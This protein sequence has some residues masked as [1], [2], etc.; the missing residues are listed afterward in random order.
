MTRLYNDPAT[1]KDDMVDG[2]VSAYARYVERVPDAS[3]VMRVGG[4]VPG[5]VSVIVGGGSGHY[6]AFCGL[7]GPGLAAGAVIGDIFTSPSAEQAYRVGRALDGG[8]GVLFSYGNY[9]GDVMNFGLAEQRLRDDGIDCRTVLVTDDIASAPVTAVGKR[10]GIAG[11]F[12]VFKVA[13]AAAERGD[14]ID[15]VERLAR[16]TN[17]VTRTLGVAFAGC[18]FPGRTE[19]LFTVD[20]SNMELGLGIHGEPGVRTAGKLSAAELAAELVT[21]LLAERPVGAD[22]RAAVILNGLGATKYEELFVVWKDVLPRLTAAGVEVVTPEVGELVTSLDMA[23]CSL[24][25]T[26]LDDELTTLWNAPADTP[27]YRRGQVTAPLGMPASPRHAVAHGVSTASQPP[28]SEG[29]TVTDASREVAGTVRVAVR[30]MRDAVAR[31][32]AM[33]GEIDAVAGDG[34]HGRG[35]LRGLTGACDA[36]EDTSLGAG[37]ALRTAGAAWADN[38][39][40]SSGVLWGALLQAVGA[41]IGDEVA[42]HG[43]TVAQALRS[44]AETVAKL[45]KAKVGDKTMLDAL[46]PFVTA[47]DAAVAAGQPLTTAW[48]QAARIATEAAEATRAL[49]PKVGRARP[50][51]GKSVGTPDPGAVSLAL[52]ATAIGEVLA[53]TIEKDGER[54]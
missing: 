53:G 24:T 17:D 16:K 36:I 26:W 6:P 23:G 2:F 30:A 29:P 38:G 5:K 41:V 27:A 15:E 18:T 20:P 37:G 28:K 35:M 31:H 25:L 13:G 51:A 48:P 33:L 4:P 21:E 14:S 10:R 12:S 40:G 42:P 11:D 22:G 54:A 19:P 8:A 43:L 50:L 47:L 7:V 44:G 46:I 45:G 39:A 9:A 1:F 52:C 49:T 34:D 3:G 32:E